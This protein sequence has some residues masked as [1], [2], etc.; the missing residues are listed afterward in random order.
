MAF[1]GEGAHCV[2]VARTVGGLEALDDRIKAAGGS[3]IL[4]KDQLKEWRIVAYVRAGEIAE[5]NFVASLKCDE[6]KFD[7]R[8]RNQREPVY[9]DL[10]DAADHE[11]IWPT[12]DA[13]LV[14]EALIA[15]AIG[16]KGVGTTA[17]RHG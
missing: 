17:Q 14:I 6:A 7:A 2:L 5:P 11:C 3:V 10:D 8:L 13:M 12:D 9:L 1:A 4:L 15:R 16:L